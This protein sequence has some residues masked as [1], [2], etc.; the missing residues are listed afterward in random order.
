L[1]QRLNK[2]VSMLRHESGSEARSG[3]LSRNGT[4]P[5]V[6]PPPVKKRATTNGNSGTT[7]CAEIEEGDDE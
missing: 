5:V 4:A 3:L 2:A 7:S 6:T 1:V